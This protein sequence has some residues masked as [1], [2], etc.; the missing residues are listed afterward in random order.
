MQKQKWHGLLNPLM[1]SKSP[2]SNES[3]PSAGFEYI[4]HPADVWVHAWGPQFHHAIEQCVYSLMDTMLDV[5][6]AT[7]Q[8]EFI[9]E[10]EEPTKGSLLIGFLSEFLFLFD[11]EGKIVKQITIDPIKLT[12][13]GTFKI[14]AVAQGDIFDPSRHEPDTE[15]KAITYS[16]LEIEESAHRTDIKIIYDI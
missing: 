7:K 12:P 15:V 11:T 8:E 16:Y 4:D 2:Q 3:S 5:T 10:V 6:N 14:R 13:E 9:I 1:T